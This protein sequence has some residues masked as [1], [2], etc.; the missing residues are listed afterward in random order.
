MSAPGMRGVSRFSFPTTII[1]GAGSVSELPGA[2]AELGV[3]RPL[4]VTDRPLTETAAFTAVEQTLERAGVPRTVFSGVHPN[5]LD[6]D[7]DA[8]LERYTADACDGIVGLGGGSSLDVS[9]ALAVLAAAGGTLATYDVTAGGGERIPDSLPPVIGIPTTAG[10]GSEV[11]KCAVITSST[12]HRKYMVCHPAMLPHRAILDPELTISLPARLTAATGM[13]AFTHCVESLTAPIFHPMCDAIAVKGI[14]FVARYLE[15][16]VRVP[17]DLEAR[18]MMLLAASMGAVAFQKDLGAAHSLSHALSAACGLQHGLAN[19]ICLPP[20]MEFNLER[21][22]ELYALI[23][24][25]FGL[26]TFATDPAEAAGIAVEQVR[27][28]NDRIGIPRTLREV[29]VQEEQLNEVVE[30]AF[31]DPC[32]L[33]NAR[34][35]TVADLAAIL[36]S[37]WEGTR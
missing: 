14:E 26:N 36:R 8:A 33:T 12:E 3:H 31:A 27:G 25:Y 22:K 9:K 21:A 10:T 34:P 24:P 18:G 19:A 35:C 37:A 30:K 11:G 29:G 6:S 7:V 17:D 5:P 2:L 1:F 23:P 16:A 13:D 32:H 20:V 15:R 4:V 28:L